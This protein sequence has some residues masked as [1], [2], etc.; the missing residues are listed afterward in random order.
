MRPSRRS[1]G[2]GARL[3]AIYAAASLVPILGLGAVQ[4]HTY[5]QQAVQQG[6]QLGRAQAA[7]IEEVAVAPALR[8]EGASIASG[9]SPA[10]QQ[11]LRAATDLAVFHDSVLHLRLRTFGGRV[12]FADDGISNTDGKL[13]NRDADV[14]AAA[15]GTVGAAIVPDPYAPEVNVIRVLQPITPDADNQAVG[16]LEVFLPYESIEAQL[17]EDTRRLYWGLGAALGVLYLV[18]ALISWSST[19]QLRRFAR[20]QEHQALHDSLTGLPNRAAFRAAV[21]RD[22]RKGQPGLVTLIDVDHF[23]SVNDTLG[24]HAGDVL[25]Q[26]IAQRL[27][28]AVRTD[29]TVARLGGDEFAV[30]LPGVA[31]IA[32]AHE[33]LTSVRCA[34][35]EDTSIDEHV[36][37]VQ[38]T[39]GGALHPDHGDSMEELLR[40]ADAAMYKGK[41]GANGGVVI[42]G[43]IPGNPPEA[44]GAPGGGPVPAP[45]PARV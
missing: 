12:V 8:G 16:V 14:E 5:Q 34:V 40:H 33:L 41:H 38:T 19:R 10:A 23:K 39:F 20:R 7:V 26:V 1:G 45:R 37:P 25:L 36:L 21:E 27:S 2:A 29:D 35:N 18:L 3:F 6:L 13:V 42:Y 28:G 17:R 24:H 9:I 30:L 22:L 32:E 31:T 15:G 11:R 4:V 44:G 43:A